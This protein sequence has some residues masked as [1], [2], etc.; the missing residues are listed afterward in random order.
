MKLTS[1]LRLLVAASLAAASFLAQATDVTVVED[2][3][4]DDEAGLLIE[5]T[6][7]AIR[8]VA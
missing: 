3:L 2:F 5:R 1:P 7:G 6:A 4:S 8:A